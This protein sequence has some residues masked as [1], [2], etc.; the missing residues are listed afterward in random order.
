MANTNGKAPPCSH[1][2]EPQRLPKP[3]PE[4]MA[5]AK[6]MQTWWPLHRDGHY[7]THVYR[8]IDDEKMLVT[9]SSR[10]SPAMSHKLKPEKVGDFSD[11]E[12]KRQAKM[13]ER[14][15]LS[16]SVDCESLS[17]SDLL[18]AIKTGYEPQDAPVP[19]DTCEA[20]NDKC[21]QMHGQSKGYKPQASSSSSQPCHED[22]ESSGASSQ[23]NG[24]S[25]GHK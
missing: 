7:I 20:T 5:A 21:N 13:D 1:G 9:T 8:L 14:P 16:T 12:V 22:R 23:Y 18:D 10:V 25:R 19:D 11:S 24:V 4:A 3:K 17:L 2:Y 15:V 6:E